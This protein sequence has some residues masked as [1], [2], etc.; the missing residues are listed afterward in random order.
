M[1]KRFFWL[2]IILLFS[3]LLIRIFTSSG[4]PNEADQ[5]YQNEFWNNY[6]IYAIPLP[7]QLNLAGEAVPL[8]RYYVRERFDRELLINSY[9]QSQTVQFLKR[10][11]RYFPMIEPILAEQNVPDDFKYLALIESGLM[12]VVSPAGATGFWQILKGTGHDLGLEINNYI[13]ERYHI[14]KAT[15]AACKYLKDS[16]DDYGSWILAAASYNM[17][18]RRLKENLEKQKVNDYFDL[19]LNEETSRYVYRILALKLIFENPQ[20]AGFYYRESDLYEPLEYN[21]ILVDTAITNLVDFALLHNTTYKELRL[22]NPWIRQYE[23]PNSSGK[24]YEIKMPK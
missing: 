3:Y 23:I 21:T 13:D 14:E 19:H 18:N 12:N 15:A 16:K 24:V 8:E 20:K 9:W 17:G 6:R 5:R 10:A 22:L 4:E 1:V 2:S 11:N 7:E